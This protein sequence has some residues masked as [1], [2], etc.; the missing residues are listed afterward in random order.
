MPSASSTR[1]AGERDAW[2]EKH[3]DQQSAR[4]DSK[5]KDKEWSQEVVER[6]LPEEECKGAEECLAIAGSAFAHGATMEA[7]IG[8]AMRPI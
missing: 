7:C 2:K 5:R 1:H 3:A 6:V 8:Q 4:K